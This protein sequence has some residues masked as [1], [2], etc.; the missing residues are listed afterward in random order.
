[1]CIRDSYITVGLDR[2]RKDQGDAITSRGYGAGQYT[3]FHHP[4]RQDE[5]DGV[6]TDVGK[7]V[8]RAVGELRDKFLHFVNGASSDTQASDRLTER[9]HGPLATCR[10]APSAPEYMRA[11]RTCA[12]QAGTQRISMGV[13][14]TYA[15]S[16]STY[17]RTQ[18]Y[19][20]DH[21]DGVPV[22]SKIECDWPY[23]VRRYNGGG[24]NSYDYQALVLRYLLQG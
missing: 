17:E 19:D 4:P 21:L 12:E 6:M 18:Y 14:P 13:T 20:F 2:N 22:R 11:C 16:P 7:N 24:P 23:A 9:G 1:M 8:M 5:V 3:L 15:G 10:F